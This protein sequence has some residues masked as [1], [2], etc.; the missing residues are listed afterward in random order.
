MRVLF[1]LG[2]PAHVYQYR[3]VMKGLIDKG[4]KIKIAV[5][6]RENMVKPLLDYFGFDYI[7]LYP[8]SPT[9]FGKAITMIKDDIK[10]I[11]IINKFKP[12]L[13]VGML[14]PYSAQAS[15][16][17]RKPYIGFTD[18]EPTGIQLLL[19]LPFTNT[20]ITP[21][22]FSRELSKKK[23]IKVPSFK[24]LAYL[25]KNR[26]EPNP[27]NIKELGLKKKEKYAILRFGA[28]DASHDVGKVGFKT[29]DKI[30]LLR[31]LNK[32]CKVFISSE[33]PLK[34][35]LKKYE[36]RTS[37]EKMLDIIYCASLIIGDTQTMTTESACLGTPA[38]RSNNW[39][40]PNDMSNFIELEQKYSLIYNIRDPKEAIQKAVDLIQKDNIKNIWS[41]KRDRLMEDKID[42]SSFFIWL[43]DNY[44]NS[45]RKVHNNPK[46]L[47]RFH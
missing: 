32:Y 34:N 23:H 6:E 19:A 7:E 44:P 39:V 27:N 41:K 24:E 21:E 47:S 29:A 37:P 40:G 4:H 35:K 3:F 13:I 42:L 20:V 2:H 25:H 26:F 1:E 8:T 30:Q 33:L 11:G 45:I 15:F 16:V 9:M 36:L 10:L 43:I 18:S 12:D 38:I 22:L 46:M 31:K 17:T 14:S 28:F 5:R